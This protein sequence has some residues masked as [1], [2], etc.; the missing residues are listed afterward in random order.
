M[1]KLFP[2]NAR[3]FSTLGLGTLQDATYCRVTEERNGTFELEMDYPITGKR[4]KDIGL[5][6]L[7]LAKS[8]PWSDLQAFRVYEIS[9]PING[10]VTISAEHISYDMSGY[11]VSPFRAGE[12]SSAFQNIVSH[13]VVKDQPFTFWTDKKVSAVMEPIVPNNMRSLLGGEEGSILDVYGTG[14]YEFDNFD[15]KFHLHR[16][17]DRGVTIRYGKNLSDLKQDENCSSVFTGVYPYWYKEETEQDENGHETTTETLH[18]LP[19]YI[20]KCPGEFDYTRIFVL[21]LSSEFEDEPTD[22]EMVDAANKYIT[23]NNL[24]KPD[25]NL[26]VSFEDLSRFTNG[27]PNGIPERVSLCDTVTVIF[28]KL[29]VSSKAKVIKTTYDAIA[30]K[31]VSVELGE[32]RRS[33]LSTT[34][35]QQTEKINEV[36][37]QSAMEKAI[38]H[39]TKLITGGLGGNVIFGNSGNAKYPDEILIM[40]TPNIKTAHKVWRW[41]KNGLGYSKNGYEGP[42]ETAIT[43]DGQIVA[44]FITTGTLNGALI[45]AGTVKANAISQEYRNETYAKIKDIYDKPNTVGLSASEALLKEV[46]GSQATAASNATDQKLKNYYGKT[47]VDQMFDENGNLIDSKVSAGV[48]QAGQ[49]TDQKLKNFYIKAEIDQLFNAE[50]GRLESIIKEKYSNEFKE[51]ILQSNIEQTASSLSIELAKRINSIR[52][53]NLLMGTLLW[54]NLPYMISDKTLSNESFGYLQ[55]QHQPSVPG[56]G[57]SAVT[58]LFEFSSHTFEPDT[59]YT[60]N[61]NGSVTGGDSY[62]QDSSGG[63]LLDSSGKSVGETAELFRV[64][65]LGANYLISE[66][67]CHGHETVY[68]KDATGIT[69]NFLSTGGTITFKTSK[70]AVTAKPTVAVYALPNKGPTTQYRFDR[71]KLE[72]GDRATEYSASEDDLSE[73]LARLKVTYDGFQTTV[74]KTLVE[75]SS[76]ISDNEQDISNNAE[77][78]EANAKALK[79][80]ETRIKNCESSITQTAQTIRSEVKETITTTTNSLTAGGRNLLKRTRN[81]DIS[82][83]IGMITG[84]W[85]DDYNQFAGFKVKHCNRTGNAGDFDYIQWTDAVYMDASKTYIF[86]FY[87]K[88]SGVITPI[89]AKNGGGNIAKGELMGTS[90]TTTDS[91]GTIR[92]PLTGDWKRYVVKY[93]TLADLSRR[94]TRNVHLRCYGGNDVYVCGPQ[95]ECGTIPSDWSLSID[96]IDDKTAK[97]AEDIKKNAQAITQC[98]SSI[99][100]TAS[101]IRLEV[102]KTI[103]DVQAA[104]TNL[105]KAQESLK[106]DQDDF[107]KETGRSIDDLNSS[108][109]DKADKNKIISLINQ[110]PESVDIS[111]ERIRLEG[112][113]SVNNAFIVEKDGYAASKHFAAREG[114][115]VYSDQRVGTREAYIDFHTTEYYR[116]GAYANEDYDARISLMDGSNNAAGRQFLVRNSA[117]GSGYSGNIFNVHGCITATNL[118]GASD[119]RLKRNIDEISPDESKKLIMS[120]SPAKYRFRDSHSKIHHGFIYQDVAPLVG[121]DSGVL[122]EFPDEKGNTYG[123]LCYTELIADM[124]NVIQNQETRIS[125]LENLLQTYLT[126]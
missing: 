114:I 122:S 95:L 20:V 45:E 65:L 64:Q 107:S 33:D 18:Q 32:T 6:T 113:T 61:F 76:S 123:S 13:C 102:S 79:D 67:R 19:N 1:I 47:D 112:Y 116:P 59:W 109:G 46:F 105:E 38:D 9:K 42:Y 51:L 81:L 2:A 4:Y 108:L 41:N 11:S 110:S 69:V 103:N 10:I 75:H 49:Q 48:V 90:L 22:A 15:V 62:I 97:N 99:T 106:Q 77:A 36:P 3:D 17:S 8:N 34:I 37:T 72:P 25:V 66:Y 84:G 14:E 82:G 100:Q 44:N 35:S 87:A 53:S 98:Q 117:F 89:I 124:V 12:I 55:F 86:S 63:V 28:P 39:A 125:E 7:I 101:S 5:R 31:Y 121:A 88:G 111:A 80:N 29:K 85:E 74:N 120:L 93:T 54:N 40:D 23:D 70:S 92:V 30:D 96:E 43:A 118:A 56:V 68:T 83:S 91:I 94:G 78:I 24:N 21:D 58:K 16:G 104:Q 126:R 27:S 71:F 119:R 115:D 73:T 57:Y 50:G 52:G 60:L 26:T